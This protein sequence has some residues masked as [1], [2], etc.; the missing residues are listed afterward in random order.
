MRPGLVGAP[1]S[2]GL[3]RVQYS[4][5]FWSSAGL[6]GLKDNINCEWGDTGNV[7]LAGMEKE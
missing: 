2:L 3:P 5:L 7:G 1:R 6:G 4:L